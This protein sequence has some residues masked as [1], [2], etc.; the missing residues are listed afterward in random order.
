MNVSYYLYVVVVM[1]IVWVSM[2]VLFDFTCTCSEIYVYMDIRSYMFLCAQF[3]TVNGRAVQLSTVINHNDLICHRVHRHEP[4][5]TCL[6][7]Q[8]IHEDS[9]VVVVNKPSSIPV[10][11]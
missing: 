5:V 3:V 7:I 2:S 9:R 8:L 1:L 11:E 6:P 10:S 4:P